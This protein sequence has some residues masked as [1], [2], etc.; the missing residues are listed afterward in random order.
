MV[1]RGIGIVVYIEREKHEHGC[2]DGLIINVSKR[3]DNIKGVDS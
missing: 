1:K 2:P 3:F